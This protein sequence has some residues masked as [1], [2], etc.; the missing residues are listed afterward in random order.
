MADVLEAGQS[1]TIRTTGE[2]EKEG[3]RELN[4]QP[5]QQQQQKPLPPLPLL[6]TLDDSSLVSSSSSSS[7]CGCWQS[8]DRLVTS[9]FSESS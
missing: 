7:R 2:E 1:T 3:R 6:P 9:S 5:L 4:S 8:L